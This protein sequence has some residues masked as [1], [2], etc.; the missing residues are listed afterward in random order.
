MVVTDEMKAHL[1]EDFNPLL[2]E[3]NADY[4][5]NAVTT[6]RVLLELNSEVRKASNQKWLR[7]RMI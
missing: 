1:A 4:Q 5:I 6:A 2:A 7:K 3:Y